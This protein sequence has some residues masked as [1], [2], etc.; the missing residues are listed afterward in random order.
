MTESTAGAGVEHRNFRVDLGGVIAL[1]ELPLG[2]GCNALQLQDI[3]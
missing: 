1:L 3:V 2:T